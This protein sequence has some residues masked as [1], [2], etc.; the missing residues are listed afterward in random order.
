[1]S[2]YKTKHKRILIYDES[3]YITG[4]NNVDVVVVHIDDEPCALVVTERVENY[5]FSY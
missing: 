1:M 4:N 2:S 3:H 5:R